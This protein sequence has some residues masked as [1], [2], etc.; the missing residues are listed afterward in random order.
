MK[1]VT[2]K[3]KGNKYY[4]E[5]NSDESFSQTLVELKSLLEKLKQTMPKSVKK[6]PIVLDTQYRLLKDEQLEQIQKVISKF[7]IF[8]LQQVVSQ[9]WSRQ[10]VKQLLNRSF[11]NIET[12]IIRSGKVVDYQGNLLLLGNVHKGAVIRAQGDIYVAGQ[13]DGII[14]AGY[15]DNNDAI[16]TGNIRRASQIRI[17]DLI[18]IVADMDQ[19]KL[20]QHSLFYINDLHVIAEDKITNL[21]DIKPRREI[22]LE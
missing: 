19:P 9:V 11:L 2:L 10:K 6:T 20:T 16:I 3:G 17:S 22:T 8:E 4:L 15:P 12:R 7:S 5:I 13:V 1:S 21:H 18:Q 14:H